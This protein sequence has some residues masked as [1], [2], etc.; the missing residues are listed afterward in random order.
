MV[1]IATGKIENGK[2]DNDLVNKNNFKLILFK[3]FKKN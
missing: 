1:K 3:L 2:N